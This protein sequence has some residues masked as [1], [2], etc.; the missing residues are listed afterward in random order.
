MFLQIDIDCLYFIAYLVGCKMGVKDCLY[1]SRVSNICL[2]HDQLFFSKL[3]NK[4]A[5]IVWK[6]VF[7]IWKRTSWRKNNE[8]Q[9]KKRLRNRVRSSNNVMI[10]Y[11]FFMKTPLNRRLRVFKAIFRRLLAGSPTT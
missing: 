10:I 8:A 1:V 5:A 9:H 2:L 7:V 6:F 4:Q 11:L 3:H